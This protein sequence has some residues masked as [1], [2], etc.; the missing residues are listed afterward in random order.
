MT[1]YFAC[2]SAKR[3]KY[4][5]RN[6][7]LAMCDDLMWFVEK[8]VIFVNISFLRS[9]FAGLGQERAKYGVTN[10]IFAMCDG[11]MWFVE[12]LIIFVKISFVT[13]YFA[14][15][16]QERAKY[17]VTKEILTNISSDKPGKS[18]R[19]FLNYWMAASLVFWL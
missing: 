6:E 15:L 5:V 14:R 19:I 7:I 11:L 12:R 2:S 8:L 4:G 3:A 18:K 1:T 10:E 13:P 16:V 9:Y 17:S